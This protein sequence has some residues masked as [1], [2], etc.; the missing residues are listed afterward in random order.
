[1]KTKLVILLTLATLSTGCLQTIRDLVGRIPDRPEPTPEQPPEP[2]AKPEVPDCTVAP[3]P[4][5]HMTNGFVWK[6]ESEND[7][8]L[9]IL[10]NRGYRKHVARVELVWAHPDTE[11]PEIIVEVGRFAGDTQNGCRPHFRFG[12]VGSAYAPPADRLLV[13]RVILR[14]ES[15][16]GPEDPGYRL[17]HIVNPGADLRI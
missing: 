11:Q 16:S 9:V 7:R 13:V 3:S 10:L 1:M 4:P 12:Q 15:R 8:R 6:V 5:E 2:P 14:P 17:L